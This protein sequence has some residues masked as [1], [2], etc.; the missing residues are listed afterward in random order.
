[1][2]EQLR[3]KRVAALVANGFEQVELTEPKRALEE[4]G[5]SS[6]RLENRSRPSATVRGR[7]SR[8]APCAAGR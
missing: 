4:A 7:S 5:D 3:G 1:M 8:R 6:P 2:A